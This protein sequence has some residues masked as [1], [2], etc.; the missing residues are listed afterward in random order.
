[1]PEIETEMMKT[2]QFFEKTRKFYLQFS[3]F[4]SLSGNPKLVQSL[5]TKTKQCS[6]Y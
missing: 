5:T 4:D 6:L 2:N 3:D 1:M